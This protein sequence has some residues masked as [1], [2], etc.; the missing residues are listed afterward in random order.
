MLWSG[1]SGGSEGRG[2][3]TEHVGSTSP[4]ALPALSL[5]SLM[6]WPWPSQCLERCPS[7]CHCRAESRA[8]LRAPTRNSSFH[9]ERVPAE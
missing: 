2:A 6:M 9:T 1:G 8:V 4:S 7:Y 5:C 3:E